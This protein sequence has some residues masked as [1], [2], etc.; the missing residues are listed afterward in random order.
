MPYL[1]SLL[2]KIDGFCQQVSSTIKVA[3]EEVGEEEDD[4]FLDLMDVARYIDDPGLSH[5]VQMLAEL[6][7]AALSMGGGYGTIAR[8]IN[9]LKELYSDDSSSNIENILNGMLVVL[10]KR[11]GGPAALAGRDNPN[12]VTRLAELKADIESR[13]SATDYDS[14]QEELKVPGAVGEGESEF[15]EQGFG[16][17]VS[18]AQLGW[19]NKEDAK[20]NPGWHTTGSALP[21]KD[22]K[23]YYANEVAALNIQL[24]STDN[25]EIRQAIKNLITLIPKLSEK[26]EERIDLTNKMKEAP[27]DEISSQLEST[28]NEITKLREQIT[29]IKK[30]IRSFRLKQDEA[31]LRE[32]IAVAEQRNDFRA[33]ELATQKLALNKLTQM[34]GVRKA[35]ARNLILRLIESMSGG[36]FPGPNTLAAEKE[37]INEASK[38]IISRSEADRIMTELR[39]QQ[40]ARLI[41]PSYAPTRGGG[42]VP[43]EKLPEEERVDL[44]KASFAALVKKLQDDISSATQA[45]RQAIYEETGGAKNKTKKINELYKANIDEISDAI[46]KKDRA[47]LLTARNKLIASVANDAR[48]T[49]GMLKGYLDAIRLEPHFRKILEDMRSLIKPKDKKEAL[50]KIDAMGNFIKANLTAEDLEAWKKILNDVNRLRTAYT[51]HYMDLATMAT[52]RGALP[53]STWWETKKQIN[54]RFKGVIGDMNRI[55]VRLAEVL[56]VQRPPQKEKYP[57]RSQLLRH[58][59]ETLEKE[60]KEE[61]KQKQSSHIYRMV[62]LKMAQENVP[63]QE[64]DADTADK[65]AMDI[66]DKIYDEIYQKIF[67]ELQA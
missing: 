41:T 63:N 31:N 28:K 50:P 13:F 39:G 67:S 34:P 3:A 47:K 32:E 37:K 6:Y 53:S 48:V 1:P 61:G 62:S 64:V 51:R 16:E 59:W 11:A 52:R 49:Q 30:S 18:P 2:R 44:E 26:V 56:S 58:M 15:A 33:K 19:G 4:Y 10:S 24:A 22:W 17:S 54:A 42:R 57:E 66:F 36:N 20:Y 40:Q 43:M 25:T 27:S 45:A 29:D 9:N 35:K 23:A 60:R 14:Y 8:A 38:E 65:L 46:R 7:R 21:F 55:E 5:Q 12:F